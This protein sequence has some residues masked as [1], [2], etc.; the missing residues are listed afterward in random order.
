MSTSIPDSHSNNSNNKSPAVEIAR[1][2]NT[3]NESIETIKQYASNDELRAELM[4][5]A[6]VLLGLSDKISNTNTS[7]SNDMKND[8]SMY[9]YNCCSY[10]VCVYDVNKIFIYVYRFINASS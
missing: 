2:T 5:K 1:A 3:I 4:Q 9:Y 7:Q 10:S 6:V 8:A